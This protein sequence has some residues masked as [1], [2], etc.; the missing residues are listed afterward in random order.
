MVALQGLVDQAAFA[1]ADAALALDDAVGGVTPDIDVR[2][3]VARYRTPAGERTF[4]IQLI[5]S[6]QSDDEFGHLHTLLATPTGTWQW[7]WARTDLVPP[8]LLELAG[9][10]RTRGAQEVIPELL[11]P[12]IEL[13]EYSSAHLVIAAKALAGR[14]ASI[15]V[16]S[17]PGVLVHL[18]LE[19]IDGA[20]PQAEH[21][22]AAITA[23]LEEG[24]VED[25]RAALASYARITRLQIVGAD[26]DPRHVRLITPDGFVELQLDTDDRITHLSPSTNATPPRAIHAG[27]SR[28]APVARPAASAGR[29]AAAPPWIAGGAGPRLSPAWDDDAPLRGLAIDRGTTAPPVVGRRGGP[30]SVTS[31][32]AEP[33][34]FGR[35]DAGAKAPL[36]APSPAPAPPP[37]QRPWPAAVASP[38][39]SPPAAPVNSPQVPVPPFQGPPDSPVP[40]VHAVPVAPGF[41]LSGARPVRLG[42]M[43]RLVQAPGPNGASAPG[44]TWSASSPANGAAALDHDRRP[45]NGT[46]S[47]A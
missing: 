16:P 35:R 21:A 14:V 23:A 17:D 7:G 47:A 39:S 10:V 29:P 19:G 43:P 34:P 15:A 11:R 40:P 6:E 20:R 25:H 41:G 37:A 22:A 27:P 4:G 36:F 33:R 28:T 38:Q 12:V 32:P 31:L 5:G 42:D 8:G 24:L 44:S 26:R 9:F 18:M 3:G 2:A 13:G 46:G 1:H 30:I 45:P